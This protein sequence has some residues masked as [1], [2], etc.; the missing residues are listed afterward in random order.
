VHILL[1]GN[2][3]PF[4]S[5]HSINI[6]FSCRESESGLATLDEESITDQVID[7][8]CIGVWNEL[9]NKE[10]T[11]ESSNDVGTSNGKSHEPEYPSIGK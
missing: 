5:R 10:L 9:P 3:C 7:Y 6:I 4:S 1:Y 2:S 8:D 11:G